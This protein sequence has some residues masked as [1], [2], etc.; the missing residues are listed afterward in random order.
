MVLRPLQCLLA[1]NPTQVATDDTHASRTRPRLHPHPTAHCSLPCPPIHLSLAHPQLHIAH[2]RTRLSTY[3]YCQLH[4]WYQPVITPNPHTHP[5][6]PTESWAC[7]QPAQAACTPFDSWR[8]STPTF[9]GSRAAAAPAHCL[10]GQTLVTTR[11]HSCLCPILRHPPHHIP[12]HSRHLLRQRRAPRHPFKSPQS[13]LHPPPSS[14]RRG[15]A[16]HS[17]PSNRT[18]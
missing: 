15:A 7:Y 18:F 12:T 16:I 14:C 1:P 9:A 8:P 6:F 13:S 3:H 17:R 2:S 5:L 10:Q 4:A 11:P